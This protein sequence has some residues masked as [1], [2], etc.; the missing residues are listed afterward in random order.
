VPMIVSTA[1]DEAALLLTNFN[2]DEAGLQTVAKNLLGSNAGRV[3][4]LYRKAYPDASPYLIQARVMTDRGFRAGAY[5]Q[6]ERKAALGKAPAYMYLFTWPSPGFGGKFGAVHGTDVP[7][8]F[9]SYRGSICGG[10]AEARAIA[11]KMAAAWVAL[12]K[13]GNPND[14]A[15]PHWPPYDARTRATMLFGKETRVENDPGRELRL[16][17]E[18]LGG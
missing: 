13:T 5:K 7:L 4:G 15:L 1:L 6:A 14:P 16:L 8:V 12:A 11:D 2:L 9:H 3:L 17:W 10:S 18:E